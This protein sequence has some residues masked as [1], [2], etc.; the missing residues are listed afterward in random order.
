MKLIA[1]KGNTDGARSATSAATV[2]ATCKAAV[3]QHSGQHAKPRKRGHVVRDL[4]DGLPPYSTIREFAVFAHVHP[5]T[6]LRDIIDGLLVAHEFRNAR[7]ISRKDGLAY[8]R[9]TRAKVGDVQRRR[10]PRKSTKMTVNAK[11]Q[12]AP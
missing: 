9:K 5:R 7:R 10:S 6:I 11:E 12:K 3:P 2:A 8:L 4:D 1:T